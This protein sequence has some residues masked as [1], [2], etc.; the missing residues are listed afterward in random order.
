MDN[1]NN[2]RTLILSENPISDIS[3][4]ENLNNLTG[5]VLSRNQ[6]TDF[7]PLR[8]LT[9][10]ES[11][12]LRDDTGGFEILRGQK[13]AMWLEQGTS[14]GDS[15]NI[16]DPNLRRTIAE[17]LSWD[18]DAPIS[19]N[20]MLT[21][22]TLFA[23]FAEIRDL[24]GLEFATNLRELD[25]ESNQ[26]SDISP[27]KNLKNL[28][29]LDLESNQISDISPLKNLKNLRNLVLSGNPISDVSSLKNLKN[30]ERLELSDNQ[31][32]NISALKNLKNLREMWLSD[33]RSIRGVGTQELEA[34]LGRETSVITDIIPDP[35]LRA[36]IADALG[37]PPGATITPSDMLALT[38][39]VADQA[40]IQN[41][42][43]LEFATNLTNL[44]LAYNQISDVS[45]LTEL[46]K[47]TALQLSYNRLSDVSG[48]SEFRQPTELR[49]DGNRISDVSGL[50]ALRNLKVLGLGKNQITDVSP[51]KRLT[52]LTWLY[53]SY[54]EI[55]DVSALAALEN[56]RALYLSYN[57]IADFSPLARLVKKLERYQNTNQTPT[58]PN[59]PVSIP[60]PILRAHIADA[61]G[62]PF[63]ATITKADMQTLK[64][65]HTDIAIRD[66]TFRAI[67][68]LTGNDNIRFIRDLTGIEFAENLMEL[69]LSINAISDISPLSGMRNLTELY[70]NSNNI[71][72]ISPLSGMRNLTALN[73]NGNNISD[74]SP[75]SDMRNL[76]AL[77]LGR[78]DE[79]SD[80]SPLSGMRNLTALNLGRNDEISDISPLSGMRNLTALNLNGNKISDISPLSDMRNLTSLDLGRNDEISDISPLSGMRNL[81][82]L[83]L[84]YN[85]ISD[86]SPLSDMRNLRSLNLAAN[87]I[88]DISPLSG[89]RKLTWLNLASNRIVDFAPIAEVVANLNSYWNYSQLK[90]LIPHSVELSGTQTVTSVLKDYTFTAK[91][92]NA[93]DQVLGGIEVKLNGGETIQTNQ[94]G[95]AEFSLSFSS[96]GAHDITVSVRDEETGTEF[97]KHFPNRVEV[98]KP[99]SIELVDDFRRVAVGDL[100]TVIFVVKSADGR[101]LEGFQVKLSVGKWMFETIGAEDMILPDTRAFFF[102]D[103]FPDYDLNV[104]QVLS[105]RRRGNGHLVSPIP[106]DG[107][108]ELIF[109]NVSRMGWRVSPVPSNSANTDSTDSEGKA[110]CSQRLMSTGEYGVSATALLNGKELLTTSFSDKQAP[111]R[112]WIDRSASVNNEGSHFYYRVPGGWRS[113]KHSRFRRPP[114]PSYR[115]KVVIPRYASCGTS[116]PSPK[117]L[118]N[119]GE[120]SP[121]F[122]RASDPPSF[123]SNLDSDS[124]S[125]GKSLIPDD[126]IPPDSTTSF[127]VGLQWTPELTLATDIGVPVIG[128]KFL[129][130]TNDQINRVKDAFKDWENTG[131]RV[132]F[133]FKEDSERADIRVTFVKEKGG[134][135]S[136]EKIPV[137]VIGRSILGS[138]TVFNLLYKMKQDL[139]NANPGK[140]QGWWYNF[141]VSLRDWGEYETETVWSRIH[142][143]FRTE[144]QR[145]QK[146]PTL[147]V[148]PTLSEVALYSTALHEIG[149]ALGFCHVEDAEKKTKALG[150]SGLQRIDFGEMSHVDK[151]SVMKAKSDPEADEIELLS[152][153]DR[154]ALKNVYGWTN[155]GIHHVTGTMSIYG[156]DS[157]PFGDDTYRRTNIPIDVYASAGVS[158]Q[159]VSLDQFKW[160]GEIRVEID[161]GIR[162]QQIVRVSALDEY[163]APIADTPSDKYVD[164]PADMFVTVRLYE[165]T[166]EDTDNLV[167]TQ[168][169]SFIVSHDEYTEKKIR[170]ENFGWFGKHDRATVTLRLTSGKDVAAAPILASSAG[171]TNS[172]VNGDGQ[173]DAE[174]LVLVSNALGQT[175]LANSR[176]D[177]NGDGIVTITDLV[178]V[179]QYLGESTYSSAPAQFVLPARLTYETVESWIDS[180]R[181]ADD[182]SLMFRQGI[183][184]LEYLLT[185]IIPEKTVLLHNYPNPFNP[186][187]W[188]PYHL[189]EPTD[190]TLTIYAIDGKVVRRLDLGHQPAGYYQSKSR[191]AHWDG[192]NN[193]GERVASGIYFYSVTAGEFFATK[194]MLILK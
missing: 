152:P 63:G 170:V 135:I 190:V 158:K 151:D 47:L 94:S 86:I 166:H 169:A 156:V 183:E 150:G 80:I 51:L 114:P 119:I 102:P 104:R 36:A 56:L 82:S 44:S 143:D 66:K 122:S 19:Q 142:Q 8:N 25:L 52:K 164:F 165:G 87:E 46:K 98:L 39:L 140:N 185:L 173:V 132:H 176:L 109:C 32:S 171:V 83:Y 127:C 179:A 128:V 105:N 107:G 116:A 192:R 72:D 184:K 20:D 138:I 17:E 29:E 113:S 55:S 131:A 59:V 125:Q 172:D 3:P 141:L 108:V 178:Q 21:L 61:L 43:G 136:G 10:L 42:T 103:F 45:A 112:I 174:D 40:G 4:L 22:T 154:K 9:K 175:N 14:I 62:R 76:T 117:T 2:L 167:D 110:K 88:S 187:T 67:R 89:M 180:A 68:D 90:S 188:I 54:N 177:V 161:I 92:T 118:S 159:R 69:N 28:R 79:I 155:W 23:H 148:D 71:S 70:L 24:T 41:L 145:D 5:L 101:V 99:Y 26:I 13:L 75:L 50:A 111:N 106:S 91:V 100:Y 48:F 144:R 78:N 157:E 30:L 6:I 139:S 162:P 38:S 194:K 123:Y 121:L 12:W 126:E 168:T 96:V 182:G 57:Q 37:K 146:D 15:V 186:E 95:R 34:L 193:V 93:S 137:E 60:D 64:V 130:G 97:Q 133:V 18:K 115:V 147:W 124:I 16:P 33:G 189:S 58:G 160:G 49:L 27:L 74:I 53:L 129:D 163:G 181:L 11:L 191:A 1:P 77:N 73:L 81:T 65:I 85:E 84:I 120:L 31:L 7:A 149:H 153:G 134:R 35:N